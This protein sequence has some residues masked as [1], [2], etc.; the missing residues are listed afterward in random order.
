MTKLISTNPA[1][2]YK[3]VGFVN[4]STPAE[5][6]RK[7][8]EANMA[9]SNWKDIGLPKRMGCVQAIYQKF[10]ERK[11]EII[12][13]IVKETG[14]SL[15]DARSEMER[16]G[17]AFKWFLENVELSM[18]DEITYEDEKTVHKIVWEPWGTAV[19]IIPWNHPFGMFVWG[20]I[21]NLLVGNTVVLK[22]SEECPLTGK[23][24]EQLI[25]SANLP[26]GVFS[27]IY[28]DGRIGKNTFK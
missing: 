4:I 28:G 20:A 3:T 16:Y 15:K 24:I 26:R 19:V 2:N 13:L 9:K 27:E 8:A 5:V 11:E 10:M 14:K 7:V 25:S 22:H 12:N 1:K 6:A 18:K 21:P 17:N 23:L